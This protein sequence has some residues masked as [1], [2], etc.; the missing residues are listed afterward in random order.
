M[1]RT[2]ARDGVMARATGEGRRERGM[3]AVEVTAAS[4]LPTLVLSY[5]EIKQGKGGGGM[6]RRK[7]G[8]CALRLGTAGV[9]LPRGLWTPQSKDKKVPPQIRGPIQRPGEETGGL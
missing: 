7:G 2:G 5:S 3:A 8:R 6:H 4:L 1:G 9:A